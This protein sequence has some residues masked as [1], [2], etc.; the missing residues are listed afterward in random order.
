M[1]ENSDKECR[2]GFEKRASEGLMKISNGWQLRINR[3]TAQ[4]RVVITAATHQLRKAR[5][6]TSECERE[7]HGGE[8][9]EASDAKPVQ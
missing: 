8:P 4:L 1:R 9:V 6:G 5:H 7:K 2:K 3:T